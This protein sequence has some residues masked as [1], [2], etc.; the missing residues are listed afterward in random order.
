MEKEDL[1]TQSFVPDPDWDMFGRQR[2][3]RQFAYD[4]WKRLI[5]RQHRIDMACRIAHGG[6]ADTSNSKPT[7]AIRRMLK[8]LDSDYDTPT[9]SD[10]EEVSEE[11]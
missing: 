9:E 5:Q 6:L 8:A 1:R 4:K 3:W 11:D 2:T 7:R 10:S